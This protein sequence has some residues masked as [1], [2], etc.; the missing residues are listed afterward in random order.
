MNH[1]RY[2]NSITITK[3]TQLTMNTIEQQSSVTLARLISQCQWTIVESVLSSEEMQSSIAIDD[4]TLPHAI[5][6]D[7]IIHFAARFQAPLRVMAL[8]AKAYPMSLK[9]ADST[10]R[11]PIHVAAKWAA[12]P[13]VM[14]YLV[15]MNPSVSGVQDSTGKTPMHYVAEFYIAHFN[16]V[17]WSRDD[18]MLQ[19]VRLL[20]NA[21]PLS[22]NLEDEEGMTCIEYALIS[23][24]H[25][26]VVKT[27]QRACRDDWRGRSQRCIDLI[28]ENSNELDIAVH[29]KHNAPQ[30]QPQLTGRRRH[31]ELV[32]EMLEVQNRLQREFSN[33]G[34]NMNKK[35]SSSF[36]SSSIHRSTTK[37]NTQAARS[38]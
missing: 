2:C 11:Y 31:H 10:G 12:S 16:N 32:E 6:P 8:L 15:K 33:R 1:R 38:A 24:A 23:D 30:K 20:K 36:N 3:R 29:K 25:I 13:D 19:V 7:I 35:N 22:V 26:K 17:Q 28:E 14:S 5:T 9:S 4:E 27:M 37:A 18:A 21:A 34:L